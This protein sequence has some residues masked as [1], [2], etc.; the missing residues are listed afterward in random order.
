MLFDHAQ[1]CGKGREMLLSPGAAA[2]AAAAK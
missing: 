1:N 2:A